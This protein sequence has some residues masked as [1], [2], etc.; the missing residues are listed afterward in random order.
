MSY[1]ALGNINHNNENFERG[2]EVTGLSKEEAQQL[3]EVNAISKKPVEDSTDGAVA[4][5]EHVDSHA[6]ETAPAVPAAPVE[7]GEGEGQTTPAAPLDAAP[8]GSVAPGSPSDQ[9]VADTL[10]AVENPQ[11]NVG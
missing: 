9:E 11:V 10:N 4:P 6:D 8:A 5:V 7:P 2:Q 3:L 1:Y